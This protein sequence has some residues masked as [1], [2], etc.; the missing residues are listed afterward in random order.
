VCWQKQIAVRTAVVTLIA[1][2]LATTLTLG[3]LVFVHESS[4]I[5]LPAWRAVNI[6][7][8]TLVIAYPLAWAV[9]AWGIGSYWKSADLD[10]CFLLGWALGC[11]ALTLSGPF[12]PYPDRGTMTLQIPL[13]LIAGAIYFAR[14]KRVSAVA[15]L[16]IVAV[17]AASPAWYVKGL[18]NTMQFRPTTPHMHINADHRRMIDALRQRADKT[19][20]LLVDK[21]RP[22]W[23]NDDLWL[24]PDYA[25]L[26]YCGHALTVDYDRKRREVTRFYH[27][28]TADEQAQFLDKNDIRFVFVGPEHNRTKFDTIPGLTPVEASTVGVL[29]EYGGKTDD[30][31]AR[32]LHGGRN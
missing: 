26:H 19:D 10:A 32:Q 29:Y 9:I 23:R 5:T 11:S 13:Y 12:Y 22:E 3:W 7:F 6:L 15:A 20:A 27:E 30:E 17:L 25:G 14:F 31:S 16:V 24:A 8:A 28:L 21:T 2:T 4:G 1:T 18:W